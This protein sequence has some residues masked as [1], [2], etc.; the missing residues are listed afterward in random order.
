MFHR[1]PFLRT[2]NWVR[3]L[4]TLLAG[5]TAASRAA[6]L[7][8]GFVE[9][10]I[11]SNWNNPV[12]VA[13]GKNSAGTKDRAYVWERYGNVWIVED[14][15]KLGSPL[16][17]LS[18]EVADYGDYGLLGFALDP[19]FAQ[20]GYLYAL[21]VVDR[22]HLLYYGTA[23][24]NAAT[25]TRNQATIGRLT[26]Y[27]CRRSD[28]FRSVDPASR[29]VLIGETISSGIPILHAS[30][31]V[32]SLVF[33]TDGTLL[34][35]CGDGASYQ[36][37]DN[38][39]GAGGSLANQ[40]LADGII[41][42]AENI[43]AFRSQLLESLN[44]KVLRI[45]PANGDGIPSNPYYDA[46]NPRSPQSRIWARGLRNPCRF[47]LKPGTGAHDP[48]A[49]NPGT[50]F[51]GDV[52]WKDIEDMQVADGP[53][54]NFGWPLYEGF[55]QQSE[56]WPRRPAG[57]DASDQ[58]RPAM[59]WNHGSS[60]A[61]VLSGTTVYTLGNSGIPVAG[62]GFAGNS[63]CGSAWYTGSDFPPEWRNIYFQADFGGQWIRAFNM[64]GANQV[65]QARSFGSGESFVF[66]TTHPESG[67]LYYCSVQNGS[68]AGTVKRIS[69]APGGNRPPV[70]A[71]S[72]DRQYGTSPLTV[73]FSSALSSDPE[74]TALTYAWAFGD[75]TT[76]T[77]ANPVKTYTASSAQRF[78]AL[79]TVRDAGG[80]T[81]SSAV[82]IT[83]NNTPPVVQITSPSPGSRYP[84]DQG[85]ITYNLTAAAAD[86]EHGLAT[87]THSWQVSLVHDNHEHIEAAISAS[88][89]IMTVSPLG[90]DPDA[91]YYYRIIL[92]VTD[93]LGLTTVTERLFMPETGNAAVVINPDFFTVT[94]GGGA[95]LDVLVNDH[96][97]VTDASLS[98]LQIVSAPTLGSAVP[99][100]VTGRIRYL[101]NAAAGG[102][103]DTFTYRIS[104]KAG[105]VSAVGTVSVNIAPAVANNNPV[106][107]SDLA[108][109]AR[110][111]SVSVALTANDTDPGGALAP[112]SIV[113]LAKPTAGSVSLNPATGTVVYR[114]N[115][116]AQDADLFTYSIADAAGLRSNPASVQISV[117]SANGAPVV[118]NPGSQTSA[119]GTT[120]NLQITGSDPNGQALTWS[121]SGLPQGLSIQA[122]TGIVSG[123]IATAAASG[124]VTVSASD[125]ALAGSVS[126][127]W[128]ITAPPTGNGLLGEYFDGLTPGVNPPLLVRTDSAI[129]FDWSGGSPGPSVP[130]DNFSARWS[131]ELIPLYTE[132]YNFSLPVD[133]GVRVWIDN[134]LVLDKWNPVGTGGYHNFSAALTAGRRTPFKV[135]YY[136]QWGGAGIVLYWFSARQAWEV[137]PAA[138]F[139]PAGSGDTSAPSASISGPSGAVSGAF[140]VSVTFSET[141]TGLT[142]GDFT[143]VNGT[144]S[145]L[146]AT[147]GAWTLTVNPAAA[148]TVSVSLP[149]GRCFD[150]GGNGNTA[151]NTFAV[152]YTAPANRAPV[153]TAPGN[154]S[155]LLGAIVSLQMQGSDPD[156]QALTWSATGLPTGL[157]MNTGTGLIGG[158]VSLSA[159]ATYSVTVTARDPLNAA[160]STTFTWATTA[161]AGTGL[162]GEYYAGLSPG[163][164]TPLLTRTDAGINFDWAGGSP[165]GTVPEDQFSVRWTADIIPEFTES[166]T[167]TIA[168]DNGYRL[169]INNA[170]IIDNWLPIGAGGWRSASVNLTAGQ[171]ASVRLEYYEEWG[172]AGI[173]LYWNS[174]RT[175]WEVIPATKFIPPGGNPANAGTLMPALSRDYTIAWDPAGA[176]L[177]RFTRPLTLGGA[178]TL[179]ESSADLRS[180]QPVDF[181]AIISRSLSGTEE[182]SVRVLD[183]PH[184]H[185][186]GSVHVH[187]TGPPARYFRLR[188]AD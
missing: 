27:T 50:L 106:A 132:S 6:T 147:G 38:G 26:R 134:V 131:G 115:N 60:K 52:G 88:T 188:L 101:H 92:R 122:S 145:Q 65:T 37:M 57:M 48:A 162:R 174:L 140:T 59:D 160:A 167:F 152:T 187:G 172:G 178:Y 94:S 141:V 119:R 109:V 39:G 114:H 169:W 75:G 99:D 9:S 77:E 79:L 32:G 35:T 83:V 5:L 180:W 49:A 125:G 89:G 40:G 110:G 175:P 181:P 171:R 128:T 186:D 137:V 34:L 80:A 10:E 47:A 31:G 138:A 151:S 183:A 62:Q 55:T 117:S 71:A 69:Y 23:Q 87:L 41:T 149:A 20:N 66:L 129:N 168:A 155:S 54:L 7:P 143:V 182:I 133:N 74:N 2:L 165:G 124:L 161:A 70:A 157:A 112:A 29:L 170:Q 72:V 184:I 135:E 21:Y 24:Y 136:E 78:D 126:F 163:S 158:T 22:H 116:S 93:P 102:T 154:Q 61:R 120:V 15:V 58:R 25:N 139:V 64:D 177:V 51:I 97:A 43:G 166:Y 84:L 108:T 103:V 11:G 91:T 42:P 85:M 96:G 8:P 130:V 63:A 176:A 113:I 45:N 30:H 105:N 16:L 17:N 121:A 19:D 185:E 144:A 14:G 127:N 148:G 82:V 4:I 53:G 118:N 67:G 33:G 150:S 76:S 28:D 90:N 18:E 56:Y 100:P 107:L 36:S 1:R 13:F 12:G 142:A 86:A 146:D 68:R 179:L 159:A 164:A 46:S 98:T 73:Q 44:G 153:V 173:I 156:N 3:V 81:A 104:T 123:T 95:M 111:Q